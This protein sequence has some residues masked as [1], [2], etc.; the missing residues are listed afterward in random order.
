[1]RISRIEHDMINFEVDME[2]AKIWPALNR[3]YLSLSIKF[4]EI[5]GFV[6]QIGKTETNK[7][8][9]DRKKNENIV[10]WMIN[11]IK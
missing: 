10:Y 4:E 8:K 2:D 6:F 5:L 11:Y 9:N 7:K 1:M 3:M